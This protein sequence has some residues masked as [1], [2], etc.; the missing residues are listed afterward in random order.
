MT[1]NIKTTCG[2]III[3][4]GAC[5]PFAGLEQSRGDMLPLLIG[6]ILGLIGTGLIFASISKSYLNNYFKFLAV[7]FALLIVAGTFLFV[8]SS[9]PIGKE[10]SSSTLPSHSTPVQIEEVVHSPNN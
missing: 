4:A 6:I 2:T 5:F 3:I 9:K 7:G 10:Q 8:S 1:N